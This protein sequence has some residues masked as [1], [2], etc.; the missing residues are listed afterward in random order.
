MSLL[1]PHP[2]AATAPGADRVLEVCKAQWP[3]AKG[4]SNGFVTAVAGEFGTTLQGTPDE[5]IDALARDSD[6]KSLPD[7]IAARAAVANGSLVVAGLKSGDFS[8]PQN[9]GH[10]VVVVPGAMNPAS[11][12][13]AAYWGS[14]D[15]AIR[16]RGGSGAP[17]SMCFSKKNGLSR[18]FV[19][20]C[21]D[22]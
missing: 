4:S 17:L 3:S 16:E 14:I 10:I 8:P 6:W 18:K 5:I 13:P 9:H 20:F 2:P 12:A 19:Y 22:W 1:A 7:G 15:R 11:W 21:C